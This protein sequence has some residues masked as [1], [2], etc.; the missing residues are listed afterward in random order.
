M[1]QRKRFIRGDGSV[2]ALCVAFRQR[3][4]TTLFNS[5]TVAS[6]QRKISCRFAM[7]AMPRYILG[8]L[9]LLPVPIKPTLK[10][11]LLL[12]L[13]LAVKLPLLVAQ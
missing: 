1:L 8:W 10:G 6:T 4:A 2:F 7:S 9:R 3:F 11:K 12:L 13:S 5:K